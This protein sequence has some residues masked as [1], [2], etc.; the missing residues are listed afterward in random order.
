MPFPPVEVFDMFRIYFQNNENTTVSL[1]IYAMEYPDRRHPTVKVFRKIIDRFRTTGSINRPTLRRRRTARTEENV[2]NVLAYV[3][4]DPHIG[5]R[6]LA[7]DL[8]ITRT[9][10]QNILEEHK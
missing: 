6:A 8:G 9:T 7:R 10:V 5:T 2:I 4:F 1:R 3:Q